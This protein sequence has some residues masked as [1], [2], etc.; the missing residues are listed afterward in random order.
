[1]GDET[2]A[3]VRRGNQQSIKLVIM[4]LLGYLLE[5]RFV[6]ENPRQSFLWHAQHVAEAVAVTCK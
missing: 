4:L 6:V 3:F 5:I 1:M 2:K